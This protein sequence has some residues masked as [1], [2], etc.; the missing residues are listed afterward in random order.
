MVEAAAAAAAA[1]AA[2]HCQRQ[3]CTQRQP[4]PEP[5]PERQQCPALVSSIVRSS[6][7]QGAGRTRRVATGPIRHVTGPGISHWQGSESAHE[8]PEREPSASGA[9]Q[10]RKPIKRS[11]LEVRAGC[12]AQPVADRR[13]E[14]P[15]SCW[16]RLA[17]LG[18]FVIEVGCARGEMESEG[19]R[20][21]GKREETEGGGA[22]PGY[23]R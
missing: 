22:L 7:Q 15:L 21:G 13:L 10:I 20:E 11:S 17:R 8:A 9:F 3:L 18:H 12:I 23:A 16:R 1:A 5:E 6:A 2:G 14:S 4:E 19:A